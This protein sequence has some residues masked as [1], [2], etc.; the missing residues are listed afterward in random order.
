[1]LEP[2]ECGSSGTYTGFC[3]AEF[4]ALLERMK[5]EP[6]RERR[7]RLAGLAE[8]RLTGPDGLHPVAVWA[9]DVNRTLVK[10]DVRGFERDRLGNTYLHRV[11]LARR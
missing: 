7:A 5:T 8:A 10:P 2:F 6:D 3:D 9:A 1:M 4:D 11:W